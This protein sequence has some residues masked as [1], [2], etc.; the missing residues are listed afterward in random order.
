MGIRATSKGHDPVNIDTPRFLLPRQG[1]VIMDDPRVLTMTIADSHDPMVN[2]TVATGIRTDLA[3]MWHGPAGCLI[4]TH[5]AERLAVAASHL[6]DGMSFSL[7]EGYRP[8]REQLRIFQE[9]SQHIQDEDPRLDADQVRTLASRHVSPPDHTPPHTT[10]GAVD[11]ILVDAAGE[12]IDVGA[13][14]DDTPEESDG[15]CYTDATNISETAKANR[16]AMIDALTAAGM[17]NYELE[18]WHWSYGDPYWALRTGRPNA[19]YGTI[20]ERDLPIEER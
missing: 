19:L 20:R 11:I 9:Y 8:P 4:R 1:T 13:E 7:A 15:R 2:L 10:G 6:P 18:W 3:S 17:V 14:L 12:K 16:T 5:V